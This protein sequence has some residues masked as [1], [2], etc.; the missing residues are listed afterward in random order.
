MPV[1]FV[2]AVAAGLAI[3]CHLGLSIRRLYWNTRAQL[4]A[5]PF[6]DVRNVC[7]TCV[8]KVEPK[9]VR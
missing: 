8:C 4:R 9:V 3:A 7:D 5:E 1:T 6:S 2:I